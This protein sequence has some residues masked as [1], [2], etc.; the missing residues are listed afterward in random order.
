L[1]GIDNLIQVTAHMDNLSTPGAKAGQPAS[2]GTGSTGGREDPPPPVGAVRAPANQPLTLAYTPM[3]RPGVRPAR[4]SRDGTTAAPARPSTVA[5]TGPERL[6]PAGAIPDENALAYAAAMVRFLVAEGGVPAWRMQSRGVP[7]TALPA[8]AGA[9][10][11]V[12]RQRRIEILITRETLP[13]T[14]RDPDKKADAA[15]KGT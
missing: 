15:A 11:G 14:V 7:Y 13:T 4:Q 9:K 1:S 2:G 6:P 5:G 10:T 3:L 8:Q 12:A